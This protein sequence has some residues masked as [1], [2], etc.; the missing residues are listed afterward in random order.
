MKK[1]TVMF[2]IV[3]SFAMCSLTMAQTPAPPAAGGRGGGRGMAGPPPPV[4]PQPLLD[5]A[6]NLVA[7]INKQDAATVNKMVASDAIYLDED[8]HAPAV[9]RWIANFTDATKPKAMTIKMVAN[10]G[11]PDST[12]LGAMTS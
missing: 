3:A 7:A 10:P 9:S 8:G 6:R 11:T 4:A 1:L 12:A 2:L 5:F